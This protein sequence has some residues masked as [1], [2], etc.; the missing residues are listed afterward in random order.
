MWIFGEGSGMAVTLAVAFRD[1]TTMV[2]GAPQLFA[3]GK[4]E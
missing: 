1:I 4:A 3:Q 2:E